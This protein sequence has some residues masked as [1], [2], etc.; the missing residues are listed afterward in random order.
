VNRFLRIQD[1]SALDGLSAVDTLPR[2]DAADLVRH[3]PD[4]H[5]VLVD[6]SGQVEGRCSLW[7]QSTPRHPGHKLGLIG[8]YA[9]EG[10]GAGHALLVHAC[11]ELKAM[12][13]TMAVGP[14]DGNTW[15]NYRFVVDGDAGPPFFLEP[16]NPPD[17]PHHFVRSGFNPMA[18]YFSSVD[19]RLD[20]DNDTHAHRATLRMAEVG[21]SLRALEMSRFQEELTAIHSLVTASFQRGFLYQPLSE[22]EFVALYEP[23]RPFVQPELV[24]IAMH[25]DRRV[26][27][28]F[29]LPDLLQARPDRRLDTAIV[30]TIAVLPE[31]RFAGLGTHL[32]A[33]NRRAAQKLGYRKMIH[34]LMHASNMSRSISSRYASVFRRYTLFSK[35]L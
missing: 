7:W 21:I 28:I 26:G 15:R 17:W 4:A 32:L 12:G 22:A 8:H 35:P 1:P 6:H 33:A 34:A 16:A 2:F 20:E 10:V 9:A 29:T 18:N 14:M 19:D 27:I 25:E 31:R 13:C 24:T 11:D 3:A 30:K 23:L 5:W